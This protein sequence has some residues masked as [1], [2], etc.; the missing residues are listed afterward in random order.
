MLKEIEDLEHQIQLCDLS[1]A[2]KIEELCRKI[3]EKEDAVDEKLRE[4]LSRKEPVDTKMGAIVR[5]MDEIALVKGDSR[6]LA[7]MIGHTGILAENVSAKVRRLDEARSR[8]SE[9]QQRV[10]DLIDLQ[11]CSQGVMTAIKEEDYE[12]GAA[13]VHRFLSMDESLLKKTADDV[14]ES[15]SSVSKAVDTLQQATMQLRHLITQKFDESVKKDDLA[16]V[17]RFFKIFPLLG[18]HDHGIE[19]FSQYICHKLNAKAQKE[20]RTSMDTAKAEKRTVV[21]FAD[22]LTILLENIARVVEV[23]QPI[24][25][26]YYGKGRLHQ[27]VRI[28][29]E[30]CDQEVKICL[31]EFNKGRH[32]QRRVA[33][34]NEY[35]KTGGSGGSSVAGHYRKPS[36]GSMDKLNPKD[37]D[38]LIGEITI[39][40][41]R[42]ELYVKF[43]KRRVARDLD[44]ST[45][46]EEKKRTA[47]AGVEKCLKDS[48][49]NRQMQELLGIYLLFERFFMEESVL[50]AIALD[51]HEP[52]QQCSSMIDDVFFIVRKCI[53]RANTTQSLDGI[54]AVINNAATAL[55][56]DFIAAIKEPLKAG[57]PSGYID[58]AQAYNV[59]QSSIQ[60]GKIQTSDTEHARSNFLVKLND[61]D[62]ATE[63][64]ET[65]WTMMMEEIRI[66]FPA[67]SPRESEKLESCS[68]GLKS[69]GD[70]LKAV[71]D[72]GMQQLRSS[73]VK[74][75][76]H[77]WVD[78][79]L[80]QSHNF[81]EDELAAYDAGE[82]FIQSLISQIDS[83]LKSFENVL[84]ARNYGI[85]VEILA[86]DVTARLE[87]VI[88]KSTF[89][90]LGGLVLDQE[91]RALST[92]L[93]GATS[94]SV[95]DKLARLTQIATILNLDRVAELSDYYNPSDT[96]TTPTW[97]L[98]PNEIRT[99]MAL[100]ID[101]RVDDIKKLKI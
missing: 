52:G 11:L 39:M 26:T 58:L 76:L 77:Q 69:V 48:D 38:S 5:G 21:A 63:Y 9:C 20:L 13:H 49:L 43:I 14:S 65:L 89:N 3:D 67:L 87:R 71:I 53:R 50:K 86:T 31:L 83:L 44:S 92:Y 91:V 42:A 95:R 35:I 17:E 18:M 88:R 15:V 61:A 79:F 4:I 40:H 54:C 90:R 68:S 96:S 70:T 16:S 94:W 45:L 47:L 93:T 72:F 100:R 33:Q 28:L 57:Y 2:D 7:E 23:N 60:Q 36:G 74:P 64:V 22:T 97:R 25:E 73:A 12:K 78:E 62:M 1:T 10:H 8:V 46:D 55:E 101:F 19:K 80:A 34:I 99:I 32:I 84:T 6:K 27:M 75:R 56:N 98:T 82:T 59:L 66:A 24:I 37:I 30:E 29:Q 51:A 85:L 81:T 41:S